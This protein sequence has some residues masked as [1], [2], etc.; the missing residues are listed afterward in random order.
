MRLSFLKRNMGQRVNYFLSNHPFRGTGKIRALVNKFLIGV[1]QSSTICP[2]RYGFSLIVDPTSSETVDRDVYF[3]GTYE[4]GTLY[5]MKKCLKRGDV[6]IDVG[7][8]IGLMTIAASKFVGSDGAVHAFEP[9]P[10]TFQILKKNIEIN[11]VHNVFLYNLAL[12]SRKE[13]AL[14]YSNPAKRGSASLVEGH[15]KHRKGSVT[16]I[17]TLDNFIKARPI[18]SLANIRMIKIDVEGWELEVLK[19]GKNFFSSKEAP[20]IIVEYSTLGTRQR[21][22]AVA[23]YHYILSINNYDVYTLERGKERIS[24]LVKVLSPDQLPRHDNLFCFRT[25]HL[26]DVPVNIFR[27]R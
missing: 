14:I 1:P 15:Q 4:A 7:S 12:G 27:H 2:T 3:K 9:N 18:L 24:K 26:R 20:I 19:G 10:E 11:H 8:Y 21:R 5:V 25:E 22:D 23:L 17:D 16:H 6:F 13:E